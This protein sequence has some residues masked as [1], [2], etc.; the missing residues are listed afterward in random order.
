M[1]PLTLWSPVSASVC[2][3]TGSPL[4]SVICTESEPSAGLKER[5]GGAMMLSSVT[6]RRP[7]RDADST[8]DVILR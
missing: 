6:G 7:R 1:T 5:A 8:V 2:P 4:R 3:G